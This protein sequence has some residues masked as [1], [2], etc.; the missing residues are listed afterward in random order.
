MKRQWDC[1]SIILTLN[2]NN[3]DLTDQEAKLYIKRLLSALR[4]K[5]DRE[6]WSYYIFIGFSRSNQKIKRER[7]HFHVFLYGCPCRTIEHWIS[8]YWKPAKKSRRESRGIA[9][10]K[11]IDRKK[12]GYFVNGYI[13]GQAVFTREQKTDD[14]GNISEELKTY[15]TL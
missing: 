11:I 6:S 1:M 13:R 15:E 14:L 2:D 7:P 3:K 4:R 8:N 10:R 12:A 9:T 5:A